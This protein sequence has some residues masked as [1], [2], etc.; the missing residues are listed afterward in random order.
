M[1]NSRN[2]VIAAVL[3]VSAVVVGTAG[4]AIAFAIGTDLGWFS[5]ATLAFC[6]GIAFASCVD[7]I[8]GARDRRLRAA[9]GTQP[10][11]DRRS[12][13]RALL[14]GPAPRD[15]IDSTV[16][17]QVVR[18]ELAGALRFRVFRLVTAGGIV[19]VGLLNAVLTGGII[20]MLPGVATASLLVLVLWP[21]WLRRRVELLSATQVSS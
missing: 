18:D 16:A 12:T 8:L 11:A 4:A 15:S 20:W 19:G 7:P 2:D 9:A 5:T 13:T 1:R 10:G 21:W 17:R 14:R 3:Y 6:T